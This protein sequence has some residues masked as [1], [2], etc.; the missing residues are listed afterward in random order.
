M[1]VKELIGALRYFDGDMEVGFEIDFQGLHT[2]FLA[3]YN[4]GKAGLE[5]KM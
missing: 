1:T 3:C 4:K 2:L 5:Y